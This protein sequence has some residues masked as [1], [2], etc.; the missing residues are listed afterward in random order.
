M[1]ALLL[2]KVRVALR[3]KDLWFGFLQVA[4]ISVSKSDTCCWRKRKRNEIFR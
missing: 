2:V 1:I 4:K 3:R